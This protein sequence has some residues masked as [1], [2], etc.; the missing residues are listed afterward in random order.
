MSKSTTTAATMWIE[1]TTR[2]TPGM[3]CVVGE[4]WVY[5]SMNYDCIFLFFFIFFTLPQVH[6]TST[7][8][9]VTAATVWGDNATS[10]TSGTSCVFM[11]S[12]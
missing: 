8:E 7:A 6:T 5:N 2:F 11:W 1:D 12:F 9:P 4:T 3:C 10:I